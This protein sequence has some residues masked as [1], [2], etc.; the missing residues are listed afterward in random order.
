MLGLDP[1]TAL[2]AE[3]VRLPWPPISSTRDDKTSDIQLETIQEKADGHDKHQSS[4][5]QSSHAPE[6]R[7]KRPSSSSLAPYPKSSGK[8]PV[9]TVSDSD[10]SLFFSSS[11]QLDTPATTPQSRKYNRKRL[12]EEKDGPYAYVSDPDSADDLQP[13]VDDLIPFK[14]QRLKPPIYRPL[15][16]GPPPKEVLQFDVNGTANYKRRRVEDPTYRPSKGD[17]P[18]EDDELQFDVDDQAPHKPRRIED[19]TYCPTQAELQTPE[20]DVLVEKPKP[21]AKGRTVGK[22][23]AAPKT[24]KGKA[25]AA[26]VKEVMIETVSRTSKLSAAPKKATTTKKK[27]AQKVPANRRVT[28][29]VSKAAKERG[30]PSLLE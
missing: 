26:T 5:K 23:K 3:A 30:E 12:R 15:Q 2:D 14:L 11:E 9:L 22:A 19:P 28:R 4:K 18:S 13:D 16:T 7:D 21:T 6:P 24:T 1:N 27:T 20:V 29:S 10:D 17:P 25:P 8:V